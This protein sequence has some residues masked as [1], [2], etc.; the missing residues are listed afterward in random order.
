VIRH[1]VQSAI[2]VVAVTLAAVA[3]SAAAGGTIEGKVDATPPKYLADTVVFLRNVPG[4][5]APQA[6][7]MDQKSMKFVP[8][9]LLAT[10]GDSV[11][12]LNHD[13]V[14]HNVYSADNEGFN[15]GS[16][17]QD[18][19]RSYKFE[20]AGAYTLLCSIHP[21]MLGYVIVGQNPFAAVVDAKGHYSIKGVPP[22]TYQLEVWNPQLK[23][24]V[25]T[26]TVTEG[27]TVQEN[28]AIKR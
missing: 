18:E 5:Y 21:E 23:A 9:I 4:T 3:T 2:A 14:N 20:Q 26:V 8:R 10:Q 12:F 27:G 19:E 28:L 6:R 1:L 24:P 25:K 22:G 11:K 16:F 15:L 7:A 13:N 17:K